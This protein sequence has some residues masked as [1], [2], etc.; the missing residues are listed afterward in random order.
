[1][2]EI[3][4][5]FLFLLWFCLFFISGF[6]TAQT[7]QEAHTFFEKVPKQY[8]FDIGYRYLFK[9]NFEQT[10]A[11]GYGAV[12]DYAWQFSGFLKKSA[13]YLSVP[14]GYTYFPGNKIDSLQPSY[15]MLQYGWI[16]RHHFKRNKLAKIMPF[17]SYSL[18]LN[19]L[20]IGNIEGRT[21][22]HLTQFDFG[23]SF[24]NHKKWKPFVKIGYGITR[25]PRLGGSGQHMHHV[26]ARVGMRFK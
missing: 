16:I 18:I 25:F 22:G 6:C 1:M 5:S 13:V 14:L 2:L 12:F 15:K 10:T 7:T 9:S 21:F 24:N 3:R 26:E 20:K 11:Q 23:F 17:A 4:S 19:Q 8:S